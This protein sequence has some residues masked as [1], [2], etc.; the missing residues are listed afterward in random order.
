MSEADPT[1]K[2]MQT[3][4]NDNG[5]VRIWDPFEKRWKYVWAPDAR[6]MIAKGT[7][8]LK[9]PDDDPA[10]VAAASATT[11][12]TTSQGSTTSGA[13]VSQLTAEQLRAMDGN[14]LHELA[15]R[16]DIKNVSKL[17]RE[18]LV[19]AIAKKHGIQLD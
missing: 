8:F 19:A 17:S 11:S 12:A 15:V 2:A 3:A 14:V 6:E 9:K 7:G 18:Q 13:D 16:E 5:Q 4:K 10:P 1:T